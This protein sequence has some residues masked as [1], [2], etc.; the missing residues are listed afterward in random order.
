MKGRQYNVLWHGYCTNTIKIDLP[1]YFSNYKYIKVKI[2]EIFSSN[3]I[4]DTLYLR[5]HDF[6]YERIYSSDNLINDC[7]LNLSRYLRGGDRLPCFKIPYKKEINMSFVF[8][9]LQDAPLETFYLSFEFIP[10]N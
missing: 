5:C 8:T 10:V 7:V 4:Y 9:L 1:N 2:K 6:N 3:N